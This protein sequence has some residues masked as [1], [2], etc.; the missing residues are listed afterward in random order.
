[1]KPLRRFASRP[2]LDI[3][4]RI[5]SISREVGRG[6]TEALQEKPKGEEPG[7]RAEQALRGV[8]R[9]CDE[10]LE[11]EH[12]RQRLADAIEAAVQAAL[13][14]AVA[15]SPAIQEVSEDAARAFARG[16]LAE[17]RAELGAHGEGRLTRSLAASTRN[18]ASAGATAMTTPLLLLAA[19]T[20][21][22]LLGA[23]VL[24]RG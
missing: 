2:K 5:R 13:T 4:R 18:V 24:R 1:M 15:R 12:F 6:V 16:V 7:W 20:G 23:L 17:L 19:A 21:L 22:G 8:F 9:A 11:D 10:G 14:V 3:E